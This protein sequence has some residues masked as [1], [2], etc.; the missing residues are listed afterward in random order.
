MPS[1]PP[2]ALRTEPVAARPTLCLQ[3]PK[4]ARVEVR[5][6]ERTALRNLL[7]MAYTGTFAGTLS[8]TTGLDY[9]LYQATEIKFNPDSGRLIRDEVMAGRLDPYAI[10]RRNI[11]GTGRC[12][13]IQGGRA[14]LDAIAA[15]R[16]AFEAAAPNIIRDYLMMADR[17]TANVAIQRLIERVVWNE[18]NSCAAWIGQH[19]TRCPFWDANLGRSRGGKFVFQ[20]P[21]VRPGE[22]LEA[23][24]YRGAAREHQMQQRNRRRDDGPRW[25]TACYKS[26]KS[27]CVRTVVESPIPTRRIV[28][29]ALPSM[30][31][32]V[33]APSSVMVTE[34]QN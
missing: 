8:H 34:R 13:E 18:V 31:T 10:F 33:S 22:N 12:P 24:L 9:A 23:C 5:D 28:C 4:S 17:T 32:S 26:R 25:W 11:R 7:Q 15:W 27:V 1:I 6:G 19:R 3:P 21:L 29:P 14:Q 20:K 30:E 2:R 16:R